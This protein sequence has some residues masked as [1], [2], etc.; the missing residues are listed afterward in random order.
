VATFAK[1]FWEDELNAGVQNYLAFN[2]AGAGIACSQTPLLYLTHCCTL[3]ETNGPNKVQGEQNS[4]LSD[5]FT[6]KNATPKPCISAE[7]V[8]GI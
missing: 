8:D 4:Q 1:Q 3:I 6:N 7:F 5:G 2:S